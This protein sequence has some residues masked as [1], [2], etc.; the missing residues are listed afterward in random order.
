[1]KRALTA[2]LLLCVRVVCVKAQCRVFATRLSQ[3]P[4]T[5][6]KCML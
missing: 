5:V 2:K 4:F 3:A 1:M 6:G